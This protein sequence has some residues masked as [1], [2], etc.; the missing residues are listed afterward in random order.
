M[1]G[2]PHFL[3]VGAAKAGTTS[4]WAYLRQNPEIYLSDVK[5]SNFLVDFDMQTENAQTYRRS[6]VTREAD[7]ISLFE[8][9]RGDQLIGEVC[10]LYLYHYD[11]TIPRIKRYLNSD[12]TIILILRNPVDRC[13][14]GYRMYSNQGLERLPLSETL[15]ASNRVRLHNKDHW[16]RHYNIT[17]GLYHKQVQAYLEAFGRDQVLCIKFE[18]LV[19]NAGQI[20]CEVTEYLG[21]RSFE[22]DT[23]RAMNVSMQVRHGQIFKYLLVDCTSSVRRILSP[24]VPDRYKSLFQRFVYTKQKE[25]LSAESRKYLQDY[26]RADIEQLQ[27]LLA[28]DLGHWLV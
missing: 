23:S 7:Y 24:Y 9:A 11:Q 16:R 1:V 6:V 3:A 10:P 20:L 15:G 8:M 27:A 17:C 22:Y 19:H 12:V 2:L 18:D 13:Y 25:P 28:W 14:S 5:E 21:L 4:I 26:Y